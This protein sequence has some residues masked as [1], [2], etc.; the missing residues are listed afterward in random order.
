MSTLTL[1]KDNFVD[2]MPVLYKF[3]DN[4]PEITI[5]N[6]DNTVDTTDNNYSSLVQ[7]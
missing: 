6:S 5:N 3:L 7:R 2:M 4:V 1:T